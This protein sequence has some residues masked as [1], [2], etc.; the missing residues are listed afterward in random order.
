[1]PASAKP[2]WDELLEGIKPEILRAVDRHQLGILAMLLADSERL[3]QAMD[4][5]PGD[6]KIR[7]AFVQQ[8]AHVHKLSAVFGLAPADR[9]R[10]KLPE[11]EL[12]PD[13]F[14][15]FMNSRLVKDN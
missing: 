11:K 7:R 8:A 5:K 15:A 9:S 12:G 4:D 1:M 3:A 10:M 13:P 6:L 2:K 14:E